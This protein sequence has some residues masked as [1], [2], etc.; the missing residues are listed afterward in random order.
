MLCHRYTGPL[1]IHS[2]GRGQYSTMCEQMIYSQQ[3]FVTVYQEFIAPLF[4]KFSALPEGLLHS[5]IQQLASSLKFPLG[6]IQVVEGSKRQ[7]SQSR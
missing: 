5:A 1:G 2:G 7:V 6:K 3:L 4:D